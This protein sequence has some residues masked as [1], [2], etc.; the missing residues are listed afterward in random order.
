MCYSLQVD[1]SVSNLEKRMNRQAHL[2][3]Y[4]PGNQLGFVHPNTPV[5]TSAQSNTIIDLEWGLIPSWAKDK[6]IQKNTLNAKIETLSEKP[7]FRSVLDRR[8][9]VIVNGFYEYQ[10]LDEKGKK[11]QKYLITLP[12]SDLFCLAGL[13][14]EWIDKSTGEVLQTFT[15]I[16]TE[17]NALMREIHNTKQRMPVVLTPDNEEAWLHG[18]NIELFAHPQVELKAEMV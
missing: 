13:W 16:T 18:Q 15:I 6:S 10:W 12:E 11:K 2:K 5:V 3:K 17:A 7:S 9:L 1:T 4:K 8:C 14:S